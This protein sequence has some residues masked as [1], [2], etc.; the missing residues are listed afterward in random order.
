MANLRLKTLGFNIKVAR[1]KQNVSQE[2]LAEKIGVTRETISKIETGNSETSILTI[3]DIARALNVD[4]NE[5][6]K[7]V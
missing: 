7:D 2:I 3:L 6:L 5:F 4:I 1:M